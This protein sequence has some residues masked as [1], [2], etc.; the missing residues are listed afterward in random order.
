DASMPGLDGFAVIERIKQHPRCSPVAI[1]VLTTFGHRGDAVRCRE[2][3]L[4]TYL[5]KPMKPADLFDAIANAMGCNALGPAVPVIRHSACEPHDER[6][7]A[8]ILLAEDNR[9]N[10]LFACRL[11]KKLGHEVIVADNGVEALTALE[12]SR[13]D[14]VFMDMQMPVMD[15]IEATQA[16]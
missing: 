13:F 12:R 5:T 2:L 16:I 14:L 10:Q 8:V 3:G 6:T 11:L 1:I 15:G 4:S 9:V 7:S